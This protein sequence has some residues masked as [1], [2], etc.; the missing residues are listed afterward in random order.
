M[1]IYLVCPMVR[2]LARLIEVTL[3]S[4]D[5]STNGLSDGNTLGSSDKST[6]GLSDGKKV[7]FSDGSRTGHLAQ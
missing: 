6:N 4:S 3:G 2:H 1:A 7:G 5:R